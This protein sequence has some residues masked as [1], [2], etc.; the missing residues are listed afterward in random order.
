MLNKSSSLVPSNSLNYI[1]HSFVSMF[2]VTYPK[3]K[4][5]SSV[6]LISIIETPIIVKYLVNL[7]PVVILIEPHLIKTVSDEFVCRG[8]HRLRF[9]HSVMNFFILI[10][11]TRTIF[12]IFVVI[13]TG[14]RLLC[15]SAFFMCLSIRVS[16]K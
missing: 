9:H 13:I 10:I 3:F 2:V 1:I 14:I 12:F 5:S 15:R 11:Y 7:I 8:F 6:L 4:E 16:F